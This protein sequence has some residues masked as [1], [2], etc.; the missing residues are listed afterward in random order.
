AQFP[1]V[2]L[3]GA[4]PPA[5]HDLE[6]PSSDLGS[7]GPGTARHGAR[8]VPVC[9]AL[10]LVAREAARLW[11]PARALPVVENPGT[12]TADAGAPHGARR[13][14]DGYVHGEADVPGGEPVAP[15]PRRQPPPRRVLVARSRVAP[16][17]ACPNKEAV[18]HRERR[19]PP[20]AHR[21]PG[22]RAASSLQRPSSARAS[23]TCSTTWKAVTTSTISRGT[24]HRA[25][26]CPCSWSGP[27]SGTA[28]GRHFSS[29]PA[30]RSSSF[31]PVTKP[32]WKLSLLGRR[33]GRLPP[34]AAHRGVDCPSSAASGTFSSCTGA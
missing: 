15:H 27:G 32:V 4:Q 34:S 21:G 30:I 10:G 31:P 17:V 13:G 3:D 28:A 22:S 7:A 29:S 2:L 5:G 25:R 1:Q 33:A 6:L 20:G 23:C 12:A 18:S 24:A 14:G 16:L 8:P 11:L 9:L 26:R 19:A